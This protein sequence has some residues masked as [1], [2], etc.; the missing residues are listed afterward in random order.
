M[1]KYWKRNAVIAALV[2]FVAAAVVLNWRFNTAADTVDPAYAEAEDS[3]RLLGETTA[4]SA[5][6]DEET[7]LLDV[8]TEASITP[9]EESDLTAAADTAESD[10]F[11]AARLTRQRARD[12]A[13][14][15]LEEAID[16][17]NL[18]SEEAADT[19]AALEAMASVTMTESTIEGLVMAKGFSDCVVF[20]GDD[21]ISVVVPEP[22]GGLT[23]SDVARIT[24]VV[25]SEMSYTA[26]QIRIVGV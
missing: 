20:A 4:V 15:L 19:S 25:V 9:A 14:A 13:V 6:G 23:V 10:Y 7:L 11:S 1:K 18:T 22:E 12:A 16:L 2:V 21:E 17:G 26:D 5:E 3:G 8:N 24:D